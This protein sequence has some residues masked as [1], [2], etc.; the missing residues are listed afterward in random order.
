MDSPWLVAYLVLAGAAIVQSL[1]VALQAW[2]HRRRG[3]SCLRHL[4][5]YRP[6]G[7]A[8]VVVPCKGGDADLDGN[9]RAVFRQDYPD[10]E[11]VLVVESVD[12][13]ACPAI[14]RVKAAHP[15]VASR[16]L[17]AGRARDVGQKVH[18][19]CAA[20]RQIPDRIAYLAFLDSDSQPRPEWLRTAVAQLDQPGLEATTGYR[21]FV[22]Q[23]PTPANYLLTSVN[24][25]VVALAGRWTYGLVWGGAWAICRTTFDR[26]DFQGAW[27]AALSDDLVAGRILSRARLRIRFE[28][29]CVVASPLDRS[30]GEAFSFLRRQYL[31]GRY[32]ATA[33]WWFALANTSLRNLAWLASGVLAGCGLVGGTPPWWIAGGVLAVLY[34]LDVYRGWIVQDAARVYFGRRHLALGLWRRLSPWIGPAAGLVHWLGVVTSAVGRTVAWRGIR[35][36][37]LRDGNVAAVWRDD[38]LPEQE[39]LRKAA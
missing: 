13:P 39:P 37:L 23:R 3:R 17:I 15:R 6:T 27:Q 31:I 22:P 20:T 24:A 12:D 26:L 8:L 32:C 30:L 29:G 14:R 18:N 7:R 28:P 5:D 25:A 21:W 4:H 33:W 34:A 36:R 19:L 9:L 10:Y 11:V 35:Y 38:A 16:L 1:L 2:E